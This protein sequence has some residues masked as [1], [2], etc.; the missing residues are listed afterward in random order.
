MVDEGSVEPP[1]DAADGASGGTQKTDGTNSLLAGLRLP[2]ISAPM[3]IASGPDL[4]TA[5]CQAGIIGSFPTLNARTGAQLDEWLAEIIASN[6]AFA[7]ANP[8]EPLGSLAANLIVH[9]TNTRLEEDLATVVKYH[10]PVVITSLGAKEEVNQAVH[11]YGGLVLHDVIHNRFAHKAIDKGADGLIAV[12]AGAG[13][14]AGTL[15]PF[16]L[17]REIRTWFSGF[18]ALSGSIAHGRSILAARALGA[19]AAYIG[20]AFLSTPQ[21]RIAE[22]YR[23]MILSSEASDIVY[24]NLF[25]GVHGN[26]LRG[27]IEA[28]GLDPDNLPVSSPESMNF[29]KGNTA[30]GK[31]PK[32]WKDIWGAG[33]GIGV[34]KN[35]QTVDELVT[36]WENE[37][38]QALHAL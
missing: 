29:D 18:I 38:L 24:S 12:A 27:S 33:Q 34:I 16:A 3:F 37:Y 35:S 2:V 26:Y 20:S 13:G 31:Q 23:D 22:G 4:V 28:A 7:E 32:P 30:S 8:G 11:S 14:H 25:T 36:R 10:V 15:S 5:Q 21:A 1:P 17:V 19:D 6:T 9:R